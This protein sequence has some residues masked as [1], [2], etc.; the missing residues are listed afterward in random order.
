MGWFLGLVAWIACVNFVVYILECFVVVVYLWVSVVLMMCLLV[1]VYSIYNSVWLW[2]LLLMWVFG[3]IVWIWFCLYFSFVI[4]CLVFIWTFSD[5]AWLLLLILAYAGLFS[6][7]LAAL[8]GWI[9][10]WGFE[11]F[12][13]AVWL[14]VVM[15]V[16]LVG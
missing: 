13:F 3:D 5:N 6:Y 11:L 10:F 7:S 8:L 9:V 12:V 14:W 15:F 2:C 1:T 4:M 16:R